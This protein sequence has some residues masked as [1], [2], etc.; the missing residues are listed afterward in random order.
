MT[1][2]SDVV[3]LLLGLI[4]SGMVTVTAVLIKWAATSRSI[5]RSGAVLFLLLMMVG[6]LLGA[7]TYFLDPG[8]SGLI[9]GLWIA[10]AVMSVSVVVTFAAYLREV[11]RQ[12]TGEGAVPATPTGLSTRFLLSVILLV[13]LNEI[14]MGWVFGMAAGSI[15]FSIGR[16]ASGPAP[17]L[18][19]VVASPWFLFSMSGEMVLTT[20]LLRDRIP[21]PLLVVLLSQSVIMFLSPP[22]LSYAGWTAGS[23]YLSSAVMIGLFVYLMEFIYQHR[24]LTPGF[25]TYLVRLLAVYG[26]MMAG[27]FLWIAYGSDLLFVVS[28]LVEMVIFFDAVVDHDRFQAVASMPWQLHARWAFGLLFGIFVAEVFMGALLDVQIFPTAY[29]AELP[30]LPLSGPM[31]TV[32]SNAFWNGFWFV[33]LVT[34]STWFLAMMGVEMGALVVLKYR[35]TRQRELRVRLALMMGS[36]ALAA[37][38]FPS[39]YYASMFPSLP[40]G[41]TVP[42]LGWSMGIG[43][44]PLATSVFVALLLTYVILGSLT[45]LFGRRVVCSVFCTAP[46]MYQGTA[47]DAMKSFNRTAPVARKYLGSRFSN[48]YT[49]T[50]GLAMGSLVVASFASYYD[51]QGLLHWTIGGADPTVFLFALYFGIL[52]YVLF[53]TIPYTGNYNCVTMGWC[54]TGQISAA[55]SRLGFFKLKVRDKNVCKACTTMD[56][57]KACPVGLVDMVGFFRTKGSYRSAKCCGVG[58]CAGDCPYGNLYLYDVRHFVSEKLGIA[59]DPPRGMRLP[60][61]KPSLKLRPAPGPRVAASPTGP[62]GTSP[63]AASSSP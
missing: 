46:L 6:M 18:T 34:G 35:E 32:V 58:A 24:Q 9:A 60:M 49:A 47:I 20:F 26:G 7:L 2:T 42:V 45:F 41:T 44:A 54:Y 59:R 10:S 62:R 11:V 52:W 17:L 8:E 28:V 15:P 22:A 14:L 56:C 51:Q 21:R 3:V 4:A 5:L 33:A 43:S 36:Y 38:Y 57:A 1:V 55:F 53:V 12:D 25:A 27:L 61:A 23:I 30:S 50:T 19:A 48:A 37:V 16:G 13:L 31:M 29:L 40:T 39:I 63:P